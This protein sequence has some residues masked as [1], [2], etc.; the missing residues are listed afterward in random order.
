MSS[1][2][3]D[4]ETRALLPS[5]KA[6]ASSAHRLMGVDY[7]DGLSAAMLGVVIAAS[8]YDEKF[9]VPFGAYAYL[10]A[11]SRVISESRAARRRREVFHPSMS[12]VLAAD[13][14]SS[15]DYD[16]SIRYSSQAFFAEDKI[17]ELL[18][19]L[20]CDT[21]DILYELAAGS[22]L[23]EVGLSRGY[24]AS[25]ASAVAK[26]AIVKVRLR[27]GLSGDIPNQMDAFAGRP[28]GRKKK[29]KIPVES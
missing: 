12:P 27:I 9:G 2:N 11:R 21:Q 8:K 1:L 23:R 16:D 28:M 13:R 20:D 4:M 24:G 3:L 5:L 25:N 10:V 18:S 22:T 7:N 6:L 19:C 26:A 15:S 17:E 14:D 29:N